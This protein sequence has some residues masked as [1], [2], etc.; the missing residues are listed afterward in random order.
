MI[1]ASP[2]GP[3]RRRIRIADFQRIRRMLAY[4]STWFGCTADLLL[5]S[6]AILILYMSRLGG[7]VSLI[8]LAGGISSLVTMFLQIPAGSIVD[9]LGAKR[10]IFLSCGIVM[11]SFFLIASAPFWG[12]AGNVAVIAGVGFH[13]VSK[14]LWNVSWYLILG[15]ILRPRE[16]GMF[17]GTMRFSY[18]LLNAVVFFLLGVALKSISSIEFLQAI[19]I[20]VGLLSIGR[21][22][23]IAGIRLNVRS[24]GTPPKRPLKEA[25]MVSLSNSSLVGAAIY[26]ALVSFAFAPVLQLAL[27]YFN[28]TMKFDG[29]S[30]QLISSVGLAGNICAALVYGKLLKLFGMRFFQI[31]MHLSFLVVCVGFSLC[32]P[33]MPAEATLCS[34]LFFCAC[35]AFTCF[36]C[37]VSREMLALARPGNESMATSFS[38]TYQMFG[39][40][41]GRLAGSQLL[42]CG[43]LSSSWVLAGHRVTASQTLF[44][45]C[46]ALLFFLL[47]LLPLLPSVV[48][49]HNDY[50]KP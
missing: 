24:S 4:A 47:I 30:V 40:A 23:A 12:S 46:G 16:R 19:F 34:G 44:L 25:F 20:G 39:T 22:L 35:F 7:S 3:G 15:G 50:Y 29:G 28:H 36:G 45:C 48:P 41:A 13:A 17:L 18:Y 14:A 42:G 10:G 31:A 21:I 6:S 9:R 8:L 1:P 32:S 43:C 5:D 27:I 11:G 38:L 37:N 49:K 33:G 2:E 26:T